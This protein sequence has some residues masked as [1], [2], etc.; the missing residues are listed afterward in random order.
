MCQTSMRRIKKCSGG[1]GGSVAVEM[2]WML[3]RPVPGQDRSNLINSCAEWK[4]KKG[5]ASGGGEATDAAKELCW[6]E[7]NK[8]KQKTISFLHN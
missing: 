8:T 1:G 2:I 7:K 3:P 6:V 4:K 5:R